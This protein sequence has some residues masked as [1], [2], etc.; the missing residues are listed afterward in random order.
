[1]EKLQGWD[2]ADRSTFL[3][4]ALSL[5]PVGR[6][7]TVDTRRGES[8]ARLEMNSVVGVGSEVSE[9]RDCRETSELVQA[10]P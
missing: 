4:L 7:W 2:V 6:C 1:M 5:L 8:L 10:R 3:G 9:E